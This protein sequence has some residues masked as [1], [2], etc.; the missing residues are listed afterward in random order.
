MPTRAQ[1]IAQAEADLT[2]ALDL[3]QQRFRAAIN[4]DA[5]TYVKATAKPRAELEA[6]EQL[7]RQVY[8]EVLGQIDAA[9]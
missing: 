4:A 2:Q 7:A 9:P 3:A 6:A 1:V 5:E 8:N